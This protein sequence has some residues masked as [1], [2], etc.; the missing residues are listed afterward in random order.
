MPIL[1]WPIWPLAGHA[2]LGQNIVVGFM[3]ILLS[4]PCWGACQEGVALDPILLQV[5]RT[6]V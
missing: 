6:T 3:K 4:W 5:N 1:P 2:T